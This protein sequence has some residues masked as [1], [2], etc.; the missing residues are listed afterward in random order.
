MPRRRAS[1]TASSIRPST[2]RL[3]SGGRPTR[4]PVWRPR[5]QWARAIRAASSADSTRAETG[6]P[7]C[8]G[9]E[10]RQR[11]G[12]EAEHGHAERL[13]QLGC[14]G[15]VEQRLHAGG[16]DE[17]LS[18]RELREVGRDVGRRGKAAMDAAEPAGA[19][20]ADSGRAADCERAADRRRAG[21]ALHGAGGEVARADLARVR[22]EAP[23][24]G[25]REPDAQLAV[26]DADRRGHR[27]RLAGPALALEPDRHALR[28]GEAVRDQGRLERDDRAPLGE[29]LGDL[30]R[31]REQ[32]LDHGMARFMAWHPSWLHI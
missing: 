26:E 17:R 5:P 25:L 28:R 30:V 11:V 12:A 7:P 1:A 29:R 4:T 10:E 2:S 19:H 13:E 32:F 23:E 9:V 20:E 24:L 8:G 27:A 31:E 15:H 3:S 22:A 14:R 21:R 6:G 16:D 18:A